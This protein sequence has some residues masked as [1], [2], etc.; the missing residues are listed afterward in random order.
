MIMSLELPVSYVGIDREEMEYI[1]GGVYLNPTQVKGV[2]MS[3]G[4]AGV[5]A[6]SIPVITA[7]IYSIAGTMAATIPGAGWITGALL[8]AN[9]TQ[10]AWAC[11][12]AVIKNQGIAINTGFPTGLTFKVC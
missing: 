5:S 4:C 7:G 3:I 10:F 9:A 1:D 8:A 11:V 6:A 12:N 2:V